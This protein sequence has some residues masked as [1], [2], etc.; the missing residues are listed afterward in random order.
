[1]VI[2]S[3]ARIGLRA[4]NKDQNAAVQYLLGKKEQREELKYELFYI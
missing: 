1:M 3:E 4:V 2:F